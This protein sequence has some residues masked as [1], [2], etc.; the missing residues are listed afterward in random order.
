[1]A[2][3]TYALCRADRVGSLSRGPRASPSQHLRATSRTPDQVNH[4][5]MTSLYRPWW[6]LQLPAAELQSYC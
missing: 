5:A 3:S 1:L 4:E 2:I 6:L